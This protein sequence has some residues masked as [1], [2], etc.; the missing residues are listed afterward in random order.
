MLPEWALSTVPEEAEKALVRGR[1]NYTAG[2]EDRR[3]SKPRS[4]ETSTGAKGSRCFR[5]ASRKEHRPAQIL[6]LS[7]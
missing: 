5:R 4:V 7:S 6:K 2:L 1:V 3:G